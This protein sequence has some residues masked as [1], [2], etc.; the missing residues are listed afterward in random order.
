MS[1]STLFISRRLLAAGLTLLFL[2]AGSTAAQDLRRGRSVG[3]LLPPDPAALAAASG[4]GAGPGLK[5]VQPKQNDGVRLPNGTV[6][7]GGNPIDQDN[8]GLLDALEIAGWDIVY[9]EHGYGPGGLFGLLTVVTV[10]SNPLDDDSDDDGI[11]DLEEYLIGTNPMLADTDGDGLSDFDEWNVWFTSPNSVDSDSDARGP[12]GDLPPNASL[13]DGIELNAAPG[14]DYTG[15]PRTSPSLADTDGDGLT[16]FEEID[17]PF[18]HPLIADLPSSAIEIDGKPTVKLNVE[19]AESVGQASEYGATL[20]SSTSST[21]AQS[22]GSSAEEKIGLEAS[23]SG[24]A[25]VFPPGYSGSVSVSVSGEL[26]WTESQEMSQETTKALSEEFSEYQTDST[27]LTEVA[28]TGFISVPVRLRNNGLFSFTLTSLGMTVKRWAQPA[29]DPSQPD[30][31]VTLPGSF[32]ALATLTPAFGDLTL[33]PG[34]VTPTLMVEATDVNADVIKGFLANPASLVLEPSVFNL[35]TADGIDFDFITES[36]FTQTA[37]LEI[38]YGPGDFET[39]RIATN[40]ERNGFEYPGISLADALEQVVGVSFDPAGPGAGDSPDTYTLQEF[41]ID[42]GMNPVIST[43]LTTIAGLRDRVYV[44]GSNPGDPAAAFW[45]IAGSDLPVTEFDLDTDG[46]VDV[47]LVDFD[48]VQLTAGSTVRLYYTIDAD[49]DGLFAFDEQFFGSSDDTPDSDGDSLTDHFEVREGVVVGE[50]Q[51]QLALLGYPRLVYTNPVLSDTDGDGWTD[52]HEVNVS[53]T[54]PTVPDT[55]GDGIPD[56]LDPFGLQPA[57]R[58]YV[59]TSAMGAADGSSWADAAALADA[60]TSA[61]TLNMDGD[62]QNDVGSI[63]VAEGTHVLGIPNGEWLM[64]RNCRVLGGFVGDETFESQRDVNPLTNQ[65]VLSAAAG[66]VVDDTDNGV[67]VLAISQN[68]AGSGFFNVDGFTL[69]GGYAD[70]GGLLDFGGAMYINASTSTILL[71]NLLVQQNYAV[72]HGGGIYHAAGDLTVENSSFF[73]NESGAEGGALSMATTGSSPRDL[74]VSGTDFR[75]NQAATRGGAVSNSGEDVI[76]FSGCVFDNNR[77]ASKVYGAGGSVDGGGAWYTEAGGT[78]TNCEFVSNL[79]GDL[80]ADNR[81]GGGAI[82]VSEDG[83]TADAVVLTNCLLTGNTAGFGGALAVKR[84]A[85]PANAR[86]VQLTNCTLV[87]NLSVFLFET[88][89]VQITLVD[90]GG[91]PVCNTGFYV[92]GAGGLHQDSG[93]EFNLTGNKNTP[94]T[95]FSNEFLIRNSI[96]YGN[97]SGGAVHT[98]NS[99]A[100]SIS[101]LEIQGFLAQ[102]ITE[103]GDLDSPSVF[104]ELKRGAWAQ[105]AMR[106]GWDEG[107]GPDQVASQ[108]FFLTAP[109]D[110]FVFWDDFI[111]ITPSVSLS[112]SVM[113]WGTS[114][115]GAK[116]TPYDNSNPGL[117]ATLEFLNDLGDSTG[118]DGMFVG[119]A[120]GDYRPADGSQLIDAGLTVV[121][122]NVSTP[123]FELL[124]ATDL[125]GQPR[126]VGEPGAVNAVVDI[127]AYEHQGDG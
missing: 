92:S 39:Y 123:E 76:T 90:G 73:L 42:D 21:S 6:Q 59:R 119:Y 82:R 28:A 50:G 100:E 34:E 10:T 79:G 55:D 99:C 63:W 17:H 103:L 58:L 35:E 104:D 68:A 88:G 95:V 53:L 78:A 60:L 11:G 13:F 69:T 45:A 44:P 101:E 64:P 49:A 20:S 36:T 87:D 124:P 118:L 91:T 116:L 111:A 70:G 31:S 71:R 7:P 29:T 62:A 72:S 89:E 117:A 93:D 94:I 109:Q 114:T 40:V 61:R 113:E 19:Y 115:S 2:C 30:P 102:G 84:P 47:S 37:Q 32:E 108:N 120:V 67:H 3:R 24:E 1:R 52:A 125:A 105:L 54:D 122:T 48:A 18:F 9:D 97:R 26:S 38:S 57:G 80:F 65:T 22:W 27:E 25:S 66:S 126:V 98:L 96:L 74:H 14:I 41:T 86:V 23:V 81:V 121:D 5:A 56:P 33:A 16:D 15:L 12:D 4:T 8:D 83:G 46:T 106:S 77:V 107:A 51:P 110:L 43:G 127:G 85:N 112:F 75:F